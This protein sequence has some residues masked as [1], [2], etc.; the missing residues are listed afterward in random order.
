MKKIFQGFFLFLLLLITSVSIAQN[1]TVTG[2]VVGE[3]GEGISK[4]SVVVKGTK[5]GTSTNNNGEFSL[6][7]PATAKNLIIS[8]VE[9]E[10]KEVAITDGPLEITLVASVSKLNE[11]IVVGYGTQK[12]TKVSGAISTVKA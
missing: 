7:V 10:S 1:K 9:F 12:V 6:S 2:K 3:K 5:L 11:V 4:A 8:S